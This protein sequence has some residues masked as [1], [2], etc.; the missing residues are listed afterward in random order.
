MKNYCYCPPLILNFVKFYKCFS[1]VGKRVL[2][3]FSLFIF[4]SGNSLKA[5]NRVGEWTMHLSYHAINEVTG[6]V[7]QIFGAANAG[8]IVYHNTD[9]SVS[10]LNKKNG[11][12]DVDISGLKFI[13]ELEWLMI[14]YENGNVDIRMNNSIQNFPEIKD[15]IF[16][17]DK[18]INNFLFF[19]DIILVATGFGIIEFIPSS[20]KF[21]NIYFPEEG[22]SLSIYD[23]SINGNNIYAATEQGIFFADKNS[24]LINPSNWN[25]ITALP[26]YMGEFNNLEVFN[27]FLIASQVNNGT[28]DK[29]YIIDKNNDYSLLEDNNGE[30]TD[31]HSGSG[32]L[33]IAYEDRVIQYSENFSQV[34]TI[35]DYPFGN[36]YPLSVYSGVDNNL[37]I[38]DN[39]NSLVRKS[40]SSQYETI[41]RSSPVSDDVFRMKAFDDEI[42][43]T[44]GGWDDQHEKLDNPGIFYRFTEG[45]WENYQLEQ[46]SDFI[47]IQKDNQGANIL[48]V[49][50][51]GDGVLKFEDYE[52]KE[53]YNS[54]NSPL[55]STDGGVRVSSLAKDK[56]GNI[57]MINDGATHPLVLKTKDNE[58]M[59]LEYEQLRGKAIKEIVWAEN[60]YVWGYFDNLP[61]LFVV[62]FN[63]TLDDIDDDRVRVHTPRDHNENLYADRI[64]A[65]VEDE[66]NNIWFATDEGVA[67]VN[68]IYG[69]FE[70][71]T[72]QPNRIRI[73][74][75]DIT[76]YL[77][78]DNIVEDIL[79]DPGNRKWFATY[80][81]GIKLF[82]ADGKKMISHYTE[83]NSPLLSNEVKTLAMK[84]SNGELFTGSS[85]GIQSIRTDASEGKKDFSDAYVFPNP[86]R[87]GYEGVITITGLVKGVNVKITDVNGNLV[88]ETIAEG[89]QATWN[90]KTLNGRKVNTGVYLV[91]ISN[92]DGSKTHIEK[93]LFIR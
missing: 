39:K 23:L 10:T 18:T 14:G 3:L 36:A 76:Q 35:T 28:G 13:P 21:R 73:T 46:Y 5:Q 57:L 92:D 22:S 38:G 24:S 56:E 20:K 79:V 26:E 49:S 27:G 16:Q 48:Y 33:F 31:I 65:L 15:N 2:L 1:Y 42:F 66:N 51:F 63:G 4:S 34:N 12:N 30:V 29:V 55:I 75:N 54:E 74:E 84:K 67:V 52:L 17:D 59:K 86:V 7:D 37:W 64:T 87:P 43:V 53:I 77:L 93:I 81:S 90:G 61:Q 19:E 78:R 80:R 41:S 71:D 68:N 85:K 72:F 47:D 83:E 82:S 62:D 44:S 11:L 50:S 58:W 32:F 69:F 8:I 25:R 60:G 70:D 45:E 89:G 40:S 91:F 9:K 88:Y 6:S